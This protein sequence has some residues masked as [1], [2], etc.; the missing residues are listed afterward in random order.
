MRCAFRHTQPTGDVA[1]PDLLV[2]HQAF[3]H[4]NRGVDAL[5]PAIGRVRSALA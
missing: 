4:V 3:E 2:A 5:H 1:D